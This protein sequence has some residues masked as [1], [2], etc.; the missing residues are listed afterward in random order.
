MLLNRWACPCQAMIR[1]RCENFGDGECDE[2]RNI[3]VL[4][5]YLHRHGLTSESHARPE[6]P[7]RL[8][9]I[10]ELHAVGRLPPRDLLEIAVACGHSYPVFSIADCTTSA[11]PV[12]Q[13]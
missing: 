5:E 9:L 8:N 2:S 6:R 1:N 10:C 12:P 7:K 11:D 3:K 4:E 13:R